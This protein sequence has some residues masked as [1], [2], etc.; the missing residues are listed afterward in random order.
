MKVRISLDDGCA[1]ASVQVMHL[2]ETG[3]NQ[4]HESLVLLP[5]SSA[6]VV[7]I[8]PDDVIT[9]ADFSDIKS[10]ENEAREHEYERGLLHG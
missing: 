2:T 7:D 6:V 5:E 1:A 3:E 8:G 10:L 9:V 4:S